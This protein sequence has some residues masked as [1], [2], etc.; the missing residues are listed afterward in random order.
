MK[1]MVK[2]IVVGALG[3]VPKD[4]R[5]F[6]VKGRIVTIQ[7]I[8]VLKSAR[9]IRRDLRRLVVTQTSAKKSF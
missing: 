9:I 6:D 2:T 4:L 7:T 8:A 5:E 3:T 1:V